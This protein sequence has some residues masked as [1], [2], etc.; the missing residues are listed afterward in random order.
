MGKLTDKALRA[1]KARD[2]IFTVADGDG[3]SIEVWPNGAMYWRH[4]YRFGGKENRLSL[5]VYPEV[6][7]KEARDRLADARALLRDGTNPSQDRRAT[8]F[9][10]ATAGDRAFEKVAKDWLAANKQGWA[11]ATYRKAEYVVDRYLVPRLKGMDIGTLGTPD[12]RQAVAAIVRPALADKARG[13][14]GSIIE[15]A[16]NAGL[17]EEGRF[18]SLKGAV[19][20]HR[21]GHIPA[22]TQPEEIRSVLVAV[23]TYESEVTR[24]ALAVAMLTAL[25]PGVVAGAR[26]KEIDLDAAE[27]LVPG[28]RMKTQHAHLVPLPRQAV[29]ALRA[30]RKFT[31]GAEF[32]FP[33]LARQ[34]TPH[35]HRDALSAALRR[36]GLQ[37]IH[38]THGFRAMFRTVARERLNIPADVL[39]AQL[40]HAKKGDV[41][42][43]YDRT[44]FREERIVAMQRW[45]DYLD[46]LRA[47]H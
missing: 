21:K 10:Q 15:L 44:G 17:R 16:I 33:P 11:P 2:R 27:W 1:L 43:A 8:K 13:Y 41:Q 26:W 9:A 23:D 7:L 38:A 3:L 29:A 47:K 19:Q 12:A 22:A 39:D 20:K 6:S 18:L 45:A 5:G 46:E 32:V 28:S 31:A 37:G 4:R 42:K 36:M 24:C 25:R 40:A 34:K 30:M 14:L 35:L